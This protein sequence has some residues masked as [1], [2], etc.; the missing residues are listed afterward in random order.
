MFIDLNYRGSFHYDELIFVPSWKSM[1]ASWKK[2][3]EC[4]WDAPGDFITKVPLK[5][6]YVSEFQNLSVELDHV[7]EFFS[8]TL[9]IPDIDWFPDR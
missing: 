6:I 9:D 7:A 2:P 8:G 1:P 4:L 5:E 3:D